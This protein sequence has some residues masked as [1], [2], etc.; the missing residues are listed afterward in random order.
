MMVEK[1]KD[2]MPA[3]LKVGT[4]FDWEADKYNRFCFALDF[5]KLLVPSENYRSS[6]SNVASGTKVYSVVGAVFRSFSDASL[7]E[8]LREITTSLG[9]E[10]WHANQLAIR[11]GYFYESKQKGGRE[12]LTLGVGTKWNTISFDVAYLYPFSRVSPLENTF[13]ISFAVELKS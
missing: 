2:F 9:L 3:N 5:N 6:T 7:R 4:A 11:T 12:Y 1:Q 13:R 10:Y 8:E